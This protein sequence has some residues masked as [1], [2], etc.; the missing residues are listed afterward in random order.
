[1]TAPL[2][3]TEHGVHCVSSGLFVKIKSL[4]M[5]SDIVIKLSNYVGDDHS[6]SVTA[7]LATDV[8]Q[9]SSVYCLAAIQAS[10][11]RRHFFFSAFFYTVN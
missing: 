9:L 1:M 10:L 3:A 7:F 4:G 2:A 5:F 11:N 8:A 6:D